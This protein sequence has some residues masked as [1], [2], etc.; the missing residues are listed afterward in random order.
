MLLIII[1]SLR[2]AHS[3][4]DAFIKSSYNFCKLIVKR[5][6]NEYDW[7]KQFIEGLLKFGECAVTKNKLITSE[8]F[9][10]KGKKTFRLEGTIL[11]NLII[12]FFSFM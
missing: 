7:N 11:K 6:L 8:S 2:T 4:H 12:K 5:Q 9:S 10:R 3:A 1:S